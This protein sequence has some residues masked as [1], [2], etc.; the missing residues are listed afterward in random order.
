MSIA[1]GLIA[2]AAGTVALNVLTYLDMAAR[3]RPSSSVPAQ[4]V[5]QAADAAGTGLA[6]DEETAENRSQGLGALLGYA[7]GLGFGLVY[8]A[9][10]SR[11]EPSVVADGLGLTLAAMVGANGPSVALGVTDP[12]EWGT[13]A[14]VMDLLP[15][16]AYGFV[17]AGVYDAIGGLRSGR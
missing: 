2:G 16:L 3:G 8:G 13:Q 15:H 12:R 7:S 1:R 6:A 11:S 9:V 5:K 10:R 17:T 14:W 4:T